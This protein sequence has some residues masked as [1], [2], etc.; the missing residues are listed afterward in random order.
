M[1]LRSIGVMVGQVG[2]SNFKGNLL[3]SMVPL[4]PRM[5]VF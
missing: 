5:L 1:G 4:I 2:L 3:F